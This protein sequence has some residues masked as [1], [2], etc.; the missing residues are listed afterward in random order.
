MQ[1]SLYNK[2]TGYY[3]IKI[4][5]TIYMPIMLKFMPIEQYNPMFD[6]NRVTPLQHF[7]F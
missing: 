1:Y 3:N 5:M 4:A 6:N 2:P 7:V